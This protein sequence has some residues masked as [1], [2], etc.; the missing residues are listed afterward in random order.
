[1]LLKALLPAQ[2]FPH[3]APLALPCWS[4]LLGLCMNMNYGSVLSLMQ[5]HLGKGRCDQTEERFLGS[6]SRHGNTFKEPWAPGSLPT[7][8]WVAELTWPV[9]AFAFSSTFRQ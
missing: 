5:C 3:T 9:L 2:S 7:M 6:H 1:M 4:P 8:I